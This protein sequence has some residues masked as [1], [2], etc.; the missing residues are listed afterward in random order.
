MMSQHFT[1]EELSTPFGK[2]RQI[3]TQHFLDKILP[4]IRADIDFQSLIKK[5]KR[6]RRDGRSRM[7]VT[8]VDRLWGYSIRTPSQIECKNSKE[9]AFESL[10]ICAGRL[11]NTVKGL[12]QTL[13]FRNNEEALWD[14]DRR[15]KDSLP[16]AYLLEDPTL[17]WAAIAVPGVYS[18]HDTKADAEANVVKITRCMALCMQ[19]DPCRRFVYGFTIENSAMKL[20]YCDRARMLMSGPFDFIKDWTILFQVLLSLMFADRPRLGYDPTMTLIDQDNGL[21]NYHITVRTLSGEEQVYR[22]IQLL[23]EPATE[24]LIGRGTRVWKA[25]KVQDGQETGPPVAL[26]DAWVD[27]HREREGTIDAR[28]RSSAM[29]DSQKKGVAKGLLTVLCHGD[30]VIAGTYDRTVSVKEHLSVT[31]HTPLDD[32]RDPSANH[33]VHYRIVY[34]EVGTSLDGVTSLAA[35][36]KALKEVACNLLTLYSCSWVHGDVSPGNILLFDS[37]ARIADLEYAAQREEREEHDKIGTANFIATEVDCHAYLFEPA[38]VSQDRD[39]MSPA[40]L[41]NS[42]S[43]L[44]DTPPASDTG[45]NQ[46]EQDGSSLLRRPPIF[47]YN[48]VHDLE[49]LWWIAVYFIVCYEVAD[50]DEK[51]SPDLS[52]SQRKLAS[53]LFWYPDSRLWALKHRDYFREGVLSLHP[54]MRKIGLALEILRQEMVSVYLDIEH[55]VFTMGFNVAGSLHHKF[56]RCFHGLYKLLDKKDVVATALF[57]SV[58]FQLTFSVPWTLVYFTMHPNKEELETPFGRARQ[59]ALELFI[60]QVLPPLHPEIDFQSLMKKTKGVGRKRSPLLPFTKAGRLWGFATK[61]PSKIER[62]NSKEVAFNSLKICAGRL[63]KAVKGLMPT[64][65]FRNNEEAL[66]N[67]NKRNMDSLPDA[68]LLPVPGSSSAD[69]IGWDAIANVVKITRCMAL[70]MKRDPCRRFVYGFS[71][72]DAAMRLWYCDRARIFASE[73]FDFIKGCK[74]LFRILFSLMFANRPQIGFDPTM[75]P[76][77][78]DGGPT[79]Y[80]L[81]VR[82]H[83]GEEHVYRTMELLS[84]PSTHDL[85]GRGTRVWKAIKVQNGQG[86]GEPVALKDAWIDSYRER[87]GVIDSRIR[88]S[89]ISEAQKGVLEMCLLTVLCHGD[90]F[91]ANTLDTTLRLQGDSSLTEHSTSRHGIHPSGRYQVHYRIVYKEIGTSLYEVTSLATV[92]K[93]LKEV[94]YS[95][96]ILASCGWI[97]GDISPGNILIFGDWAKIADLEYAVQ[98]DEREEH[99]EIGTANFIA[100]EVKLHTYLFQSKPTLQTRAGR[101][102]AGSVDSQRKLPHQTLPIDL[103]ESRPGREGP[104]ISN[105][106]PP[107]FLYNAIHD[108]ESLWWIGVYFIVCYEVVGD[109]EKEY[110][111]QKKLASE[112]FWYPDRRYLALSHSHYFPREIPHLHPDVQEIGWAL[113]QMRQEMVACYQELEEDPHAIGF[114]SARDLHSAFGRGFQGLYMHFEEKDVVVRPVSRE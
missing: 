113:E 105:A 107:A 25:V 63:G 11:A 83:S 43:E 15:K 1:D 44:L 109:D 2:A 72:E 8:A 86:I 13:R 64:L 80:E 103:A 112:L 31:A 69:A 29:T 34:K 4:P 30:V 89:A 78:L 35:V 65:E 48:A 46:A 38:I 104:S 10:R 57:Q 91:V 93:A 101:S 88:A 92:C 108:L 40:S 24:Y 110:P 56:A 106:N 47:R 81:T 5:M 18:K 97:H 52:R 16:D 42:P 14:L 74:T 71:V 59:I 27:S 50:G 6:S 94:A 77:H 26:K 54:S 102:V 49:S 82:A 37:W 41:L 28:I 61:T 32:Y 85:R 75:A 79:Q 20:W 114:E 45:G 58:T 51:G 12:K 53:E 62:R 22:T 99:D 60:E 84:E 96:L 33:L 111:A 19:R 9:V 90:V 98:K 70:C 87:E 68:Y 3:T 95:L 73:R 36:Y 21:T 76:I 100:T 23:S 17:E 67:L 7:L 39:S 66:W 55:D